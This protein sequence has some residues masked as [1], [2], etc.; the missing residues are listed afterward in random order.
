MSVEVKHLIKQYGTQLAVN[1][2][3]FK[4]NK[5]EITGF[6]GPNGAGKST[7]MKMITGYLQPD[8]GT[9]LVNGMDV[10]RQPI[11]VK[12]SIG[13]LPESN[14]LYYEMYV[15]EYLYF[16][17]CIKRL[18][19][20]WKHI[21]N[22]ITLTGLELEKNK[23]IGQLSKGY[24]QRVGLAAALINSPEVLI[25]DEPTSGLDPNQIVEIRNVIKQQGSEKTVLFSSH[26]LQEV[27]AVC[28]RAIII[29]EGKVVANDTLQNLQHQKN[30]V[31]TVLISFREKHLSVEQL[32]FNC[33]DKVE[34]LAPGHFKLFTQQEQLVRK[35]LLAFA[36]QENLNIISLQSEQQSLE[37]VFRRLTVGS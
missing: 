24:K 3:S 34:M 20:K 28:D 30:D 10:Q 26:T 15:S 35:N 21:K 27:N 22:A 25:L 29:H 31:A 11:D 12:K 16:V 5:G 1:D 36:L 17:A 4:L 33:V 14:A 32:Q 23:K 37:E 13:Y 7:T 2:I 6:L 8:G 9:V 18:T 19:Q